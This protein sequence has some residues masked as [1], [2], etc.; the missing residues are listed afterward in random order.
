MAETT[1]VE[2][3]MTIFLDVFRRADRKDDGK[4]SWE[5]FVAFFA[6]GIMGKEEL[7]TLFDDIDTHKTNFIDP[8][9]LCD[10]F[11]NH[12]GPFKEILS[13]I[14]DLNVKVSNM[15]VSTAQSYPGSSRSNQFTAR[16]LMGL[17]FNQVCAIQHPLDAATDALE[18]QAKE[19]GVNI[20]AV[21]P[22]DVREKNEEL[23]VP[24][25]I[26][27]RAKRQT[28]K[29]T[30]YEG[31]Q[32]LSGTQVA[33]EDQVDRLAKLLNRME[34][35]VNFDGLVDEEV[36]ITDDK[37]VLL[38]QQDLTVKDGQM[39]SFK[40]QLRKYI[41]VT[42]SAPGALTMS[43]RSFKDTPKFSIYEVWTSDD[44][45]ARHLQAQGPKE[46]TDCVAGMTEKRTESVVHIP[47]TWWR[48]D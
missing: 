42:N 31:N 22:E 6:D 27:R 7:R 28:S 37:I 33:L 15:L 34:K 38:Y 3:G 2:K 21:Q 32:N 24:G 10:Y 1:V 23:I 18:A 41:E 14:E 35:K 5:E 9:E 11:A 16:F 13:L 19:E 4:I 30:T 25:R 12:L 39:D 36:D 43:V 45:R 44:L 17:V 8:K 46:F 29:Q 47:S 40:T 20:I 48:R 26:V